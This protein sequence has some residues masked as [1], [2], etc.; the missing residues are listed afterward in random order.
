MKRII[1]TEEQVKKIV[2]LL[3]NEQNPN[4]IKQTQKTSTEMLRLV[5]SNSLMSFKKTI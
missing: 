5:K 1:V 3:I 4:K 2:D